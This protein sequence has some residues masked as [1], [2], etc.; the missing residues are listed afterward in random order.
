M[1]IQNQRGL[2]TCVGNGGSK[3][4]LKNVSKEVYQKTEQHRFD[5]FMGKSKWNH[6]IKRF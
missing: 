5:S 3:K 1:K 6:T 4:K 2:I